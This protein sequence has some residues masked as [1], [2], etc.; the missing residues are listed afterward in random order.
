MR[1]DGGR[2]STDSGAERKPRSTSIIPLHRQSSL[3]E[4]SR[5]AAMFVIP[6]PLSEA[7]STDAP[8][9]DG[10]FGRS[11]LVEGA[12]VDV[13]FSFLNRQPLG[14]RTHRSGRP[15]LS[16]MLALAWALRMTTRFH[17]PTAGVARQSHIGTTAWTHGEWHAPDVPRQSRDR[18]P[19]LRRRRYGAGI[20]YAVFGEEFGDP[21]TPWRP[22]RASIRSRREI[23]RLQSP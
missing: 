21:V 17:R 16:S 3:I 14:V 5:R 15:R 22:A 9:K 11:E 23:G 4:L 2:E 8:G 1:R 13:A 18:L 7:R 19:A 6:F 12:H 20:R 10:G